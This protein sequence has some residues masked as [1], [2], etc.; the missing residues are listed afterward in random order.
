MRRY[1][2]CL[3]FRAALFFT[4]FH[5]WRRCHRSQFTILLSFKHWEGVGFMRQSKTFA[6]LR[7]PNAYEDDESFR[8]VIAESAWR[9]MMLW[10]I[11]LPQGYSTIR[12]LSTDASISPHA[13]YDYFSSF[14]TSNACADFA[15]AY[16]W[17]PRRLLSTSMMAPVGHH[18]HFLSHQP[19]KYAVPPHYTSA[20]SLQSAWCRLYSICRERP[21]VILTLKSRSATHV[22]PAGQVT[23]PDIG[24]PSYWASIWTCSGG[25]S[26]RSRRRQ[27]S[28]LPPQ[29]S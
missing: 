19:A 6:P 20:S 3:K 18:S 22:P 13:Y 26:P 23:A 28:I 10:Y 25:L 16:G 14:I 29:L 24:L 9:W 1:Q 7:R 27:L 15:T 11:T 5:E 8:Y 21:L 17:S 4:G 12:W 2:R